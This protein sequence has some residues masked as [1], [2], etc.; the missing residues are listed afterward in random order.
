MEASARGLGLKVMVGNMAGSSLAAARAFLL[1]QRSNF[2]DLGGPAFIAQDL[3][4]AVSYCNGMIHCPDN[5]RRA[6]GEGQREI[7][8]IGALNAG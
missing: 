6:H 5:I 1:G 7:A 8:C 2:V 3:P 4:G